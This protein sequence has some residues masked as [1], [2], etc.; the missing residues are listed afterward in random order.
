MTTT[1]VII[2]QPLTAGTRALTP[3]VETFR[4]STCARLRVFYDMPSAVFKDVQVMLGAY[5]HWDGVTPDDWG[6]VHEYYYD[7][8]NPET[9]KVRT[10]VRTTVDM[11]SHVTLTHTEHSRLDV[12]L[13]EIAGHG[14]SRAVLVEESS[15]DPESIPE[16]VMPYKVN[17][18][19]RLVYFKGPWR[20]ELLC[21]WTGTSRSDAEVQQSKHNAIYRLSVEFKPVDEAAYWREACHTAEYVAASL[22]M[23][24]LSVVSGDMVRITL[25][26]S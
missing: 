21:V 1:R 22:L 11:S 3:L 23:K 13:M 17:V 24:L 25:Q 6:D 26:E 14:C 9:P 15:R 16:M 7:V 10:K 20:F 18:I 19:R 4:A 8:P 5:E 2:P 12:L